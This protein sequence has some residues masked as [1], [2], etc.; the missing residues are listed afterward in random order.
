MRD[1]TSKLHLSNKM[2]QVKQS[3]ETLCEWI[4][5]AE[6]WTWIGLYFRLDLVVWT[7]CRKS[8]QEQ[9]LFPRV[10]LMCLWL[11]E[12][13]SLNCWSLNLNKSERHIKI[14]WGRKWQPIIAFFDAGCCYFLYEMEPIHSVFFFFEADQHSPLTKTTTNT[15]IPTMTRIATT[16]IA[17]KETT[18]IAQ[19]QRQKW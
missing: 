18:K 13:T 14:I 17:A 4:S 6:I 7:A 8:H 5:L 10:D 9:L 19:N 16:M 3:H 12:L 2:A 15:T 11:E 1:S